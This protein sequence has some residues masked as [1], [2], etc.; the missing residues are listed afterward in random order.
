MSLPL[1]L[2]NKKARPATPPVHSS[3]VAPYKKKLKDS[4]PFWTQ[5]MKQ[6]MSC[7]L[8]SDSRA[9]FRLIVCKSI[10]ICQKTCISAANVLIIVMM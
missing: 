3:S 4:R 10:D 8:L 2:S 9:A 1:S 6:T 7:G 5:R